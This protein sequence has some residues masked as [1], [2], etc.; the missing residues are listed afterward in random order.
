MCA[1]T[2][3]GRLLCSLFSSLLFWRGEAHNEQAD[4]LDQQKVRML[5]VLES[6]QQTMDPLVAVQVYNRRYSAL[7]QLPDELLLHILDYVVDD[8]VTLYCLRRV[9]RR[10]LYLIAN[11]P[12]NMSVTSRATEVEIVSLAN[13]EMTADGS[14]PTSR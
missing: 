11:P 5:E 9:S 4:Q 2:Q 10:F 13:G 12:P 8:P 14:S 1:L 7:C 6:L 3:L